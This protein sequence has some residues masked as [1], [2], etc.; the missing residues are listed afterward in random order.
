MILAKLAMAVIFQFIVPT[1]L[2][3]HKTIFWNTGRKSH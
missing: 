2:C 3:C 1:S